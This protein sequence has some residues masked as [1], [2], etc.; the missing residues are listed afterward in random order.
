MSAGTTGA[1]QLARLVEHGLRVDMLPA[2][3]DVDTIADARAVAA[4]C[5]PGA[6]FPAALAAVTRR[7]H[8]AGPARSTT[9]PSTAACR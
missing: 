9:R 1:A 8:D 7:R 3:R 4:A 6:A 2:L 5:R